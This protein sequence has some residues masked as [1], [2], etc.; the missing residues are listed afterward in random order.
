MTARLLEAVPNFS[1]GRD[2]EVVD[3]IV[4]AMRGAGAAVLDVSSDADHHRTVVTAVG[5]PEAVEE[6]AVAAVRIA[7][8]RIDL[9]RHDGVH[10]RIG[11]ADVVPFVPLWGVTMAEARSTAHRVGARLA[12][13]V[14]LPV[15]FYGEAS[16][17]RGRRLD[18]LRRGGFEAIEGG[19]PAGREP[20]VRPPDWP[21]PG[22][23]PT[24]GAVCVGARPLL[25]AWNVI[26]DGVDVADAAGVAR[27]IRESGGGLPGLRAIARLLPRRG[28]V[29]ISMNLEDLDATP[30]MEAYRSLER[31]L[32][33]AGGRIVETEVIGLMPDALAVSGAAARFRLAPGTGDRLLSRRLFEYVASTT[34]TAEEP[35]SLH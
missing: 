19:W 9:R 24:A 6:A 22:A 16:Q 14:G 10:P 25:L 3:A 26:V 29:Q 23:H 27:R 35:V 28:A 11:A 12:R 13:E 1:E 2:T 18:E 34:P 30:P 20:D 31:A 33:D 17:P 7:A 15:Y 32:G 5:R 4:R 8:T 21:H